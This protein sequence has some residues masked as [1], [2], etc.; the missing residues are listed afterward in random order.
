MDQDQTPMEHDPTVLEAL[1][2]YFSR[3]GE[4]TVPPE[5]ASFDRRRDAHALQTNESKYLTVAL[6]FFLLGQFL[7]EFLRESLGWLGIGLIMAGFVLGLIA[8]L[9]KKSAVDENLKG[10]SA[11]A[12][13]NHVGVRLVWVLTAFVLAVAAS[14]LYRQGRVNSLAGLLWLA[15]I[16]A[17]VGAFFQADR[18]HWPDIKSVFRNFLSSPRKWIVYGIL[19][20]VVL[21]FQL[22][23]L[24]QV[25]P[26]IISSQVE[27]YYTVDGILNGDSGLWFPR[28]VV[29]EPLSYYWAALVNV[30]RASPLSFASLKL[31]YGLAGLVAVIYMFMLGKRLFDETAGFI[32]ALMLGVSFWSILQQRAVLGYGLVL[33]IMLPALYYLFKSLQDDDL[34]SLLIASALTA[35]GLLT[36]KI[37]IILVIANLII[38]ILYS[39]RK[40]G[41]EAGITLPLRIG[42]SLLTGSVVVLPLIFVIALNPAGWI[43][44]IIDQL[45]APNDSGLIG[46]LITFFRNLVSALGMV[47]WS[48]R[49]SWVDGIGGR[50]A[51]DWVSAAFF[52]FGLC[53][54]LLHDLRSDRKQAL[55][56]VFLFV[57]M[58]V[59]SALSIAQPMENPSL[60]RA[61]GAAIPAI[62]IAGRGFGFAAERLASVGKENIWVRKV[63]FIAIFGVLIVLNNFGLINSTYTRNYQASAWNASEMAEVIRN[64]DIGK[65][66]NSQA[67]VVGFPHWVDA[68]SVAITMGQPES[69][70]SI[71]PQDLGSTLE[72][73][74]SKIFLLH[75]SDTESLGQLQSLYPG[76]V[77]TTYQSLHPDKN[78]MIYLVSQ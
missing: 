5:T 18:F 61:L 78:F 53:V 2:R 70:L 32:S 29:S 71:L 69:N 34:N 26:E 21:V 54:T 55:S 48:N 51:L 40:E 30:F 60:S 23:R 24:E 20:A 68:R 56:L 46:A 50:G 8:F 31:A 67:F 6:I 1:Q 43:A 36:N 73:Q 12:Q 37:F 39:N 33:P 4:D 72:P 41:D 63:F 27:G 9:R 22:G 66:G 10:K 62:L 35:L 74:I 16:V 58:L 19:I 64:Y 3:P 75:L 13:I 14:L 38:S 44:L 15:S 28:N 11:Q 25:P 7:I 45:S 49:S 47:N 77:A 65:S 59:P 17:V 76:G 42:I 57:I 52:L